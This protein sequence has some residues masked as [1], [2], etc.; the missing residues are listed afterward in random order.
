MLPHASFYAAAVSHPILWLSPSLRLCTP[1]Y[2]HAYGCG[3]F[4]A[5]NFSSYQASHVCRPCAGKQLHEMHCNASFQEKEKAQ[6]ST[7]REAI[8]RMQSPRLHQQAVHPPPPHPTP[9]L[10]HVPA[11]YVSARHIHKSRIYLAANRRGK[12]HAPPPPTR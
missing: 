10:D 8:H 2:A 11:F 7:A 6:E 12:R 5:T 9:N 1:V 3:N 4:A